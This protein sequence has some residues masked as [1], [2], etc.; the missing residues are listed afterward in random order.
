MVSG[1]VFGPRTQDVSSERGQPEDHGFVRGEAGHY[2]E[3]AG[4]EDRRDDSSDGNRINRANG[5]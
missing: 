4:N 2:A 3:L 1:G 5:T